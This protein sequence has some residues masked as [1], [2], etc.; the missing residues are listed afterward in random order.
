MNLMFNKIFRF[1][2]VLFFVLLIFLDRD[3]A[4]NKIFLIVFLMVLTVITVFR[5][6]DSR[7]EWREIVK[8][9]NFKE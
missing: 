5:I 2:W 3:I 7:N 8:E 1:L 4:V 6:L 9:E